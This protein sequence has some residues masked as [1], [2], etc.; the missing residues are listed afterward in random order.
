MR[1]PQGQTK[2]D[3]ADTP[4][5]GPCRLLDYELEMG[6][7]VG[8]GNALG[9]PVP[10]ADALDQIF[11]LVIVNDWS[12]RDVQKWDAFSHDERI[13]ARAKTTVP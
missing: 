12:A 13:P 9:R 6:F 1:R 10:M 3:T 7:F 8:P 4:S 11:G 2:A 5:F